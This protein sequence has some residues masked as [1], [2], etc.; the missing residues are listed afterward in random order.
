VRGKRN[1]FCRLHAVLR[2]L[3][4]RGT[5]LPMNILQDIKESRKPLGGFIAIGI[6][7]AA[8]FAQMPVVKSAVQAS[9]G[10]YGVA[11][12]WASIGAVAAMWL[13]PLAQA[14]AGRY[15]VP[16]AIV[17]I[18][19][20][21]LG[22]G[23]VP[24]LWALALMLLVL[25]AG[26]G[27]VDVLINAEVAEIEARTGRP[28]MNLN[29]GLYSFAYAGAAL[30]VG[31][32]RGAGW[33]PAEVFTALL[34]PFG[35]LA[36]LTIGRLAPV[37]LGIPAG[38]VAPASKVLPAKLIWL[39]GALVFFAFL[40]EASAEGWSAL[41]IERGLGGS[42]QQGALGPALLGLM[43]GVG[44]LSGHALSRFL[45]E[46]LL[47]ILACLLTAFGLAGVSLA[48]SVGAALMFFA[49]AGFGVS[50]L[51]PL[52]LALAGRA[53][54]Q[55]MRLAVISRVSVLGYGAFFFGPP[56]MGLIAEGFSLSAA[57]MTVAI[58][59]GVVGVTL[60]PLLVRQSGV[61]AGVSA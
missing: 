17:A 61:R 14:R 4:D 25:S 10:A 11:V 32:L 41:H 28:L 45:P 1:L 3:S 36:W 37:Q 8:Y 58:V 60:V 40:T 19:L 6:A 27:V 7:W 18:A 20:G 23:L 35:V 57:F 13:A 54:P 15:A 44:R 52:T 42:A 47:M 51:A 56:L 46:T 21:L 39:A 24:V 31:A 33:A 53:V 12:L 26:S 9:D 59:I 50:V 49:L 43:M 16:L 2:Q 5:C 30:A 34:L 48:Q 22:T 55:A 38:A 29:H